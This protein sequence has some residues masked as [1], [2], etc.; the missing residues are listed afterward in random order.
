MFKRESVPVERTALSQF[1][2]NKGAGEVVVLRSA[3]DD[4]ITDFSWWCCCKIQ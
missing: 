4:A 2:L 1:E 3:D